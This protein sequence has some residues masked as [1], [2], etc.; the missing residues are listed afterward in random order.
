MNIRT[1]T[2]IEDLEVFRTIAA[3]YIDV[4]LPLEYLQQSKV[5]VCSLPTGEFCGG[6][7]LVPQGQFPLR[8][9]D[10]IPDPEFA[11]IETDLTNVAEITGLWLD[12]K[13]AN[14]T[15][16]S[17]VFWLKL[18]FDLATSGYDGFVYAYTLKKKNL[19]KIY[20]TF[21]P[22]SLFEGLTKQLAGMGEPAVEAVEYIDKGKVRAA[23]FSHFSFLSR[24]FNVAF[25]RI[26]RNKFFFLKPVRLSF[27]ALFK[28]FS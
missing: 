7:M 2:E 1:L 6:Y 22:T 25:K 5:V 12:A 27:A 11:R 21:G 24:R 16:C 9:L 26:C 18:Y 3:E 20:S 13:K 19:A 10:S 14:T 4:L 17:I 8:V 23:P 15:F 28:I